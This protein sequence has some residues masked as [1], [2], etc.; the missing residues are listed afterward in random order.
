MER[1]GNGLAAGERECV[2]DGGSL[3]ME[4]ALFQ[5]WP[6]KEDYQLFWDF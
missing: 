5:K 3:K 4:L 1:R 2:R 6:L